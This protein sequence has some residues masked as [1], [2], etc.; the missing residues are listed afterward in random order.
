MTV[1]FPP[2]SSDPQVT[3]GYTPPPWTEGSN[4]TTYDEQAEV[5]YGCATVRAQLDTVQAHV[6]AAMAAGAKVLTGG[7]VDGRYYP[8]TVMTVPGE[9]P[10]TPLLTDE[11]FG[12][13][14]PIMRVATAEEGVAA[15]NASPF[16]LGGYIF[17]SDTAP[18]GAGEGLA[19]QLVTG[20]ACLNDVFLQAF[21]TGVPFGGRRASGVG[22]TGGKAGMLAFTT[23]QVIVT[24]PPGG[25]PD[26]EMRHSYG[27]KLGALRQYFGCADG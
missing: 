21:H 26:W 1:L 9:T 14:L 18:S 15:A 10:P 11:T 5:T 7:H 17:T 2:S 20:G 19:R 4:G 8:P 12:P 25:A 22:R 27:A 6:D 23:T 3:Y 13:V 16:G 24:G